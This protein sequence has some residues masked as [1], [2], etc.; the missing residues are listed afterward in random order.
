MT[1]GDGPRSLGPEQ[2][3]TATPRALVAEVAKIAEVARVAEKFSGAITSDMLSPDVLSDLNRTVTANEMAQNTITTAQLNEQI[4]KYLKPEITLAPEAPGLIFNGQSINLSS[5]AE[6]KFLTYQW[7]HNGQAIAGATAP[8][9]SISEVN[10]TLHDGNYSVVVSND[11]GSATSVPTAL[12]VDGT[13]S[14]QTVASIGM[15]MTFCPPGTFMMGSPTTEAG[16][17]VD[18][19]QHQVTLTQ[20]FYLGKYE[21]T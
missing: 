18:E 4:L 6:G 12:Q 11:F 15:E 10:G 1:R 5:Q 19:T 20:G 3:I 8:S 2:L 9:F 7:Q 16:R 17:G 14:A 21:V 13:P